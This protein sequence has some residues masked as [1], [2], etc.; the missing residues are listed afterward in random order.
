MSEIKDNTFEEFLNEKDEL[1]QQGDENS[2]KNFVSFLET[3]DLDSR[4]WEPFLA[5]FKPQTPTSSSSSY[6]T[7]P[8]ESNVPR[9]NSSTF[10]LPN[11]SDNYNSPSS[12]Q[13]GI[14]FNLST[15]SYESQV[16]FSIHFFLFNFF[17]PHMCQELFRF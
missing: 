3:T 9:S 13:G 7:S 8:G 11:K 2:K 1:S 6:P 17:F 16:N 15:D 10:P 5:A 4:D 12:T 14:D